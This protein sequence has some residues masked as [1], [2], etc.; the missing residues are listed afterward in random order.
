MRNKPTPIAIS[1]RDEREEHHEVRGSGAAAAPPIE[2]DRERHAER[3]G[4]QDRQRRELEALEQGGAQGRVL[5]DTEFTSRV[6]Q[7]S[8]EKPCQVVCALPALKEKP[9]AIATGTIVH[10]T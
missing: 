3:H 10:T 2:R 8:I 9:T 5:Q 7:R 1:G 6:Y 4:D